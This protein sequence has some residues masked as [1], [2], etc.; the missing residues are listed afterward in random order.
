MGLIEDEEYF[1]KKYEL[2]KELVIDKNNKSIEIVKLSFDNVARVEAMIRTDSD[3]KDSLNKN[4][5]L[6]IDRKG[7]I[8]H[9]G[10]SSYWLEQL[11]KLI[12][13]DKIVYSYEQIIN[14]II[15][16]IDNENSTH[17]NSDNIGRESVKKRILNISINDLVNYLK[18]PGNEY[19]LISI[20]QT[21]Q[22]EGEKNHLSFATKFCHYC[23]ISLFKGEK[24]EDNYSIYD[25]VIK[26]SLPLY[27]KRYLNIDVDVKEYDNDYLK[28]ISYIDM[29]RKQASKEY[30]KII[31]RNGFDHLIWYYHKGKKI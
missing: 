13:N 23:S 27:I 16:A 28:Y 22:V 8:K 26:T 5:G 19:K 24:Y 11:K 6:V 10:S 20:I 7:N 14:N 25:N 1:A 9:I 21:P 29:I 15:K 30:D 17:L 31:S 4:S 3:Y 2:Q 18:Y 12:N